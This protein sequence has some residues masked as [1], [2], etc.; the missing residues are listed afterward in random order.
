MTVVRVPGSLR[1][2]TKGKEEVELFA[3]NVRDCLDNLE[4][5]FPGLKEWLCDERG[6]LRGFLNI[7]VN[8]EDVRLLQGLA[9]PLKAGDEIAL[10]PA[11]AGG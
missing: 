11:L 5:Q 2:L 7:Y 6:E 8:G 4:T 3:N 10:V 1:Q 9:T